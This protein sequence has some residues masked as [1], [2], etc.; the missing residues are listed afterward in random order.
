MYLVFMKTTITYLL[1]AAAASIYGADSMKA[2]QLRCQYMKNPL[3]IDNPAPELSWKIEGDSQNLFQG[4]YRILAASTPDM[5]LEDKSDLWDSGKVESDR[6]Y[7]VK[8]GGRPLETGGECFW[9][10]MLWDTSGKAGSWSETAYWSSGLL[11]D[12]DWKAGWIG[13]DKPRKQAEKQ[14]KDQNLDYLLVPARLLRKDFTLAKSPRRAVLYASALGNYEM[15]INGRRVAED[16]FAPG[17][18]DYRIRVYYNTYDVTEMLGKGENAVAGILA[19]GWYAGHVGGKKHRDHYGKNPRLAAQLVI[20]YQDGTSETITTDQSW[21]ASTGPI[22]ESDFLQGETYDARLETAGWDKPGYDDRLWEKPDT[23]DAPQIKFSA[24]PAQPVQVY[25]EIKPVSTKRISQDKYIFDM[26]TNFAGFARL[27]LEAP[28]GTKITLRFGERLKD[29][30]TLYTENLRA[31]RVIDTYTCKGGGPEVWQPRFTFH[32]FQYI[33]LSGYP[34]TPESDTVTGIELTSAT[35]AAGSFECSDTR[36]N[37]LYH[38][39]CQTQRANFIEVPTDCPQRDERLGWTGDA[40]A[41]IRTACLNTDVQAFFRKWLTSLFDA[42]FENSDIPMVAPEISAWVGG[43]GGPAWADAAIICPWAIYQVYADKSLLE[44]H[45]EAMARFVDYLDKSAPDHLAPEKFHCFGDWLDI[46]ADTPKKLIYT[47]YTAGNA[48]IMQKIAEILGKEGDAV[49]YEKIYDNFKQA[50]NKAYVSED[51]IIEGDSQTCYV[52]ALWFDLV[53]GK[54]RDKA[55]EHLIERIKERDWHLS[56]GFVGTRDLMHVLSKIGRNDVAYRLMFNDTFPSWLFPVK[57]GATSIWERWN[58]WTPEAGFGD[59]GMNSFSHYTYGAVG[60]WMFEN[61]AGI[62]PLKPG[63]KEFQIR[64]VITD[65][66][67]F[68]KASYECIHGR[69]SA[70]W[71]RGDDSATLSVTVPPNTTAWIYVP[72]KPEPIKTGSGEYTYK[73]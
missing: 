9:K 67:S 8:Y 25:Q 38:N 69:I 27:K 52:L 24:Y 44:K 21:K 33:E 60:Q 56:T 14:F 17:W 10:V 3:G 35:P 18:T 22:L 49:K 63:Y 30:G 26:G 37:Q 48:Q 73:F 7:A 41:Y 71:S 36:L 13:Y 45:Y 16:F 23:S 66:L 65:K 70:Q 62:K 59:S 6:T 28:Q 11:N 39:I 46:D 34:G 20:E 40:Q 42:Q 53:D 2:I 55:A 72:G 31:A 43:S 51:G 68:V 4:A 32:G 54:M 47:A 12:S 5:L 1:L 58:S 15:R 50:F 61:M 64:P 29:D 19:D 57:N